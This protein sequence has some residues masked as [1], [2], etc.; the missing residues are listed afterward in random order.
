MPIGQ[1]MLDFFIADDSLLLYCNKILQVR[2]LTFIILATAI[3]LGLIPQ[4]A[5]AT[6]Y[7]TIKSGNYT[8]SSTWENGNV[9]PRLITS[10]TVFIRSKDTVTLDTNIIVSTLGLFELEGGAVLLDGLT[11]NYISL[12]LGILKGNKSFSKGTSVMDIDS[13]YASTDMENFRGEIILEK[14][15]IAGDID[16][17]PK[18]TVKKT[19]RLRPGGGSGYCKMYFN[20]N[21]RTTV[22]FSGGE[23]RY[24]SLNYTI[25]FNVRYEDQNY[26]INNAPELATSGVTDVEIAINPAKVWNRT[27]DLLING[28]LMLTSGYFYM[29]KCNLTLGANA[30]IDYNRGGVYFDDADLIVNSSLKNIGRLPNHTY[31]VE[32]DHLIMN[33]INPEATLYTSGNIFIVNDIQ[34]LFGRLAIVD[35][36]IFVGWPQKATILGGSIYSYII[37]EYNGSVLADLGLLPDPATIPIGTEDVYAPVY[38][39]GDREA[40]KYWFNNNMSKF[41]VSK[42]VY[43]V[44]N[45]TNSSNIS[46][47]K[48]V[49]NLT[50]TVKD[51]MCE[52]VFEWDSTA[53]V[54]GFDRNSCYVSS[55]HQGRSTFWDV[56][57]IMAPA[58]SNN[59]QYSL[60]RNYP[61]SGYI[62]VFDARFVST[63]NVIKPERLNV[64]VYPNP[65]TD[66]VYVRSSNKMKAINIVNVTGDVVH[67]ISNIEDTD[68]RIDID[69]LPAATYFIV[70]FD[71]ASNIIDKVSFVK[72]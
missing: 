53:E 1:S 41:S 11:P 69:M 35:G 33:S 6:T 48:P 51:V 30:S 4:M 7:K 25:P 62:A 26:D 43:A 28:K 58:K 65:A 70:A 21:S 12:Q 20:T 24:Q 47:T 13:L 39:Y 32:I 38:A 60:R 15:E 29:R 63:P 22:I 64:L 42:G 14:L 71:E 55:F 52:F 45:D 68:A 49:V 50:W 37:T 5:E 72:Q 46:A 31:G 27:S 9:P 10:D 18:I 3:Y 56:D 57:S 40:Y 17:D 2:N 54:N 16:D 19:L 36:K 23:L 59:G 8:A 44:A 34:L 61:G 67:S 66:V